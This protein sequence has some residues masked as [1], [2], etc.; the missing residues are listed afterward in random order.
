MA[1][2]A[3]NVDGQ[4][5]AQQTIGDRPPI[6]YDSRPLEIGQLNTASYQYFNGVIDDVRI[7][8]RVMNAEEVKALYDIDSKD[9]DESRAPPAEPVDLL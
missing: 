2:K 9:P 8:S 1:K 4:L 3:S 6:G 5:S 7:Y